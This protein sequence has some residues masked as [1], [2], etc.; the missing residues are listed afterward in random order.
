[1]SSKETI[2]AVDDEYQVRETLARFLLVKGYLVDAAE[3]G[4]H[5]LELIK[6]KTYDL[7]LSDMVMEDIDGIDLLREVKAQY[8]DTPFLLFTGYASLDTAIEALR[9]GANDYLQKPFNYEELLLKVN[10]A[11]EVGRLRRQKETAELEKDNLLKKLKHYGGNLERM[12]EER[13]QAIKRSQEALEAS[14]KK[15]MGL[16]ENSP[17]I[18]YVL[19]SEGHFSFVGGAV[20]SLI[21]FTPGNLI[22]KHFTSIVWPEDVEKARFHFNERRTEKRATRRLELRLAV[23]GGKGRLFDIRY[24]TIELNAF[25]MYDNPVTQKDKTFLGTY[26]VVRDIAARKRAEDALKHSN[27]KLLIEH[28][29]RKLLSKRLIRLL[30]SDRRQV[31]ME[32]HDHIGQTLTTLKMDLEMILSQSKPADAT[33]KNS[34]Q[35]AKDKAMQA[36]EDIQNIARGLRPSMLDTLGLVPALRGLFNDIKEHADM[37]IHF[38]SQDIPKRFDPEKELAVY[39]IAQEALTNVVKHARANKVF[40]NLAKED[41]L[42]TLG[43]EDDGVGFDH[44]EVMKISSGKGSLG[45]VIMQERAV[46]LRGEFSIESGIGMGTHLLVRM[47]M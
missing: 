13:T 24:L 14:E 41:N 8:P 32:L 27:K 18:I 19:N 12:V 38:F 10:S 40:V 23:K 26:G 6:K 25:G 7:V 2:L 47:P 20:K 46:Q 34:I 3:S 11:L 29:Q 44:N 42:I 37:E 30:E 36:M 45:L 43:V 9:L 31:A 28:R 15:Y 5:A 17:D 1:M 35:L 4:S 16:V 33:L 39:R 22:G 21:G